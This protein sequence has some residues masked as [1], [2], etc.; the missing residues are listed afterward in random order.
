PEPVEYSEPAMLSGLLH[1][2][3]DGVILRDGT[4]RATFLPQV[5]EK[6]PDPEGFL[7]HLCQKMGESGNLWRHKKLQVEI[8]HAEKFE[9]MK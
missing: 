4:R 1:P 2:H 6:L 9:E 8:Y 3:E 7:T 5:W